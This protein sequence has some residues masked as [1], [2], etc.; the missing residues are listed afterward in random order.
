MRTHVESPY[1]KLVI[2]R[3][4]TIL[5]VAATSH[6]QQLGK[7]WSEPFGCVIISY[8]SAINPYKKFDEAQ[9]QFFE[10]LVLYIFKGYK[11]LSTCDNI[12]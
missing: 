5:H 9:H 11:P 7:K 8:F 1:P 10:D 4:L 3:K 12:W 2:C 6:N